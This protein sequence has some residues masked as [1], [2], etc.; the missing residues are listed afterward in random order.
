MW[1]RWLTPICIS[2]PGPTRPSGQAMTPA[3]LTSRCNGLAEL[4]QS[5]AKRRT[6][7]RSAR[8]MGATS[9]ASPNAARASRAT[10]GRRAG[11]VTCAPAVTNARTVS[12]PMPE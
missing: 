9:T 11:T 10:S 12:K 4:D 6:L 2:Q 5:D 7:A 8:S 1:P 3:L